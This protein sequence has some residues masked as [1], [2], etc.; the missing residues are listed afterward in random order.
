MRTIHA[1][2]VA[3]AGS[4]IAQAHASTGVSTPPPGETRAAA[5]A[6]PQQAPAVVD[7]NTIFFDSGDDAITPQAAAILDNLVTSYAS[8]GQNMMLIVGH[9]DRSGRSGY[10]LALSKLRALKVRSYLLARGI[11]AISIIT[12][13]AGES[14]PM[15]DTLDGIPDGQNRRV[16]ISLGP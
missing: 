15:V 14:R 5:A 8:T 2:A 3:L 10:N 7:G 4:A 13:W 12:E 11:P 6:S 9:A 1:I 16:E